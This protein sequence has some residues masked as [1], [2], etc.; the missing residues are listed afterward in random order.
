MTRFEWTDAR[1]RAALGDAGAEATQGLVFGRIWTDSRSI[2]PGDLFVALQGERMDGHD[3]LEE[4]AQGGASAAVVSESGVAGKLPFYRVTDTLIALGELAHSRRRELPATVVGI[5]GSVGKTAVKNFLTGALE[6]SYRVHSTSKNLNNR[7]GVPFTLL[8]TPEDAE[9][10]V[11]EM[12]TSEPGEIRALTAI[13]APD[14]SIVTSVGEAHLEGLGSLEG[15]MEEKLDL[16]RGT[17]PGGPV[18]VGDAPECLPRRAAEL[19]S[20]VRVAGL[21]PRADRS[22]RGELL[23]LD[24]EGCYRFRLGET[25]GRIRLPGKHG[26]RNAVLAITMAECLGVDRESAM[27]GVSKV[28][29]ASLRGEFRKIGNL[30]LILDCYN[31]NPQSLRAALHLLSDLPGEG[32]KVAVIGSMLELGP[33]EQL[34]HE[35]LLAEAVALD[36]DLTV[37]VGLFARVA[38]ARNGRVILASTPEEAWERLRPR[39]TGSETVLLK[40]S[41]GIALE[42]LIPRFEHDFGS[43]ADRGGE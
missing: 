14:A 8:S 33:D 21:S 4:A 29:P 9:F 34:L 18:V 40:G 42:R 13:A 28:A 3:F 43:A 30:T 24:A 35:E 15:V 19:R 7:I 38:E 39:L 36:F 5:T 11:V 16:I 2:L 6:E 17:K 25:E 26:V 12:G 1:V 27:R 10:A 32:G 22:S 31:S 41:R 20:E 37:G 23:E